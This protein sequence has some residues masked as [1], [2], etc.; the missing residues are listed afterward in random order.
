MTLNFEPALPDRFP[1]L[2]EFIAHRSGVV[3]KTPKQQ[4]ADMDLSPS[5]LSRKLHPTENDTQR[6]NCDDLES[7]LKSTGDAPAIV[8][9]LAAKFMDTDEARRA[10][11]LSRLESMLP[12]L[13]NMVASSRA[14]A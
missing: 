10:R 9:Y 5:M 2:R 11:T 14:A 4:A 8:E 7:W 13:M 1:S 3:S 12:E 6:L